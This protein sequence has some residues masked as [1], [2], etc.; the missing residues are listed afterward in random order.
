MFSFITFRPCKESSVL[1]LCLPISCC[2]HPLCFGQASG[3]CGW[4]RTGLK[5]VMQAGSLAYIQAIALLKKIPRITWGSGLDSLPPNTHSS[6]SHFVFH[7]G[8]Q[9]LQSSDVLIRFSLSKSGHLIYKQNRIWK[10]PSITA[11]HTTA[12]LTLYNHRVFIPGC[13]RQKHP[14][15]MLEDAVFRHRRT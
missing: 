12:H 11:Q 9:L 13:S 1:L 4:H 7:N 5:P 15:T 14:L 10:L 2:A 8:R 3:K 6:T